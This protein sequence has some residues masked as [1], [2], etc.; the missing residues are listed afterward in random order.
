MASLRCSRYKLGGIG[1]DEA[2]SREQTDKRPSVP[3]GGDDT[4]AGCAQQEG[5][6]G[7]SCREGVIARSYG[8]GRFI[9]QRVA[10]LFSGL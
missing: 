5:T 3:H 9:P 2:E 1:S 4:R 7:Y 10:G 6:V 8:N